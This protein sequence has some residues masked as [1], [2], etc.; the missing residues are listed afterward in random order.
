[1]EKFNSTISVLLKENSL[2]PDLDLEVFVR[3]SDSSETVSELLV[4]G[5]G[6][7]LGGGGEVGVDV[8]LAINRS[9]WCDC[10]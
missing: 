2:E 10:G 3:D 5:G 7:G 1:M 4:G 6:G 9:S 8:P